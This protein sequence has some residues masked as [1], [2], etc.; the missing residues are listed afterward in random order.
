MA[1]NAPVQGSAADLVKVA[2]LRV[3]QA[4]EEAGLS[5]RMLLQVHDELVLE[6][7]SGEQ[8][9]ATELVVAAMTGVRDLDVPLE[10]SVG[11][12]RTGT[13]PH[14]DRQRGSQPLT[15]TLEAG[16]SRLTIRRH[17]PT[18]ATVATTASMM[19]ATCPTLLCQTATGR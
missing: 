16:T 3:S 5:T 18:T 19:T 15:E 2:M 8:Q 7:G 11:F 1:L 13:P 6:I 4:L 9:A 12:G 17:T 14:T 10:V